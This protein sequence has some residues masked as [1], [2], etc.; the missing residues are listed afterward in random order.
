[1][2]RRVLF[3]LAAFGL[4]AVLV[5]PAQSAPRTKDREEPLPPITAALRTKATNNLKMVGLAMH[6]YHDVN[7][8]FPVNYKT[9]DGKPG[10]SWRVAILP[11]IEEDELFKQFKLDEPWDSEHNLKLAERIPKVF[12]PVRG[13]AEKGQTYLQMFSGEGT[14]LDSKGNG[15]TI[16]GITD[17]TSNTI[18]V[19]ESAKPVTWTKPDDLPFDGEKVPALGGMFD[20]EYHILMGDGSVRRMPKGVDTKAL[21]ALI[22]RAGGEVVD[23]EEAIKEAK[24]KE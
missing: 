3:S 22:T 5:G 23:L 1:M 18:M 11:Y 2:A 7:G 10:L 20:G 6:N 14:L 15:I 13:R 9:Q 19:T 12:Q 16:V 21:I 24:G 4:V 8:Q 17:G